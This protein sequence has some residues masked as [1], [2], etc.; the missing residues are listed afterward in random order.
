VLDLKRL[1]FEPVRLPICPFTYASKA[2]SMMK[3][4]RVTVAAM[5]VRKKA[6]TICGVKATP[7]ATSERPAETTV[8]TN[9]RVQEEPI[10]TVLKFAR[11]IRMV[12]YP[13]PVLV[14][15]FREESMFFS[16]QEAQI[17][18][19]ISP[20]SMSSPNPVTLPST[21]TMSIARKEGSEMETRTRR[22][23]AQKRGMG[24]ILNM[25]GERKTWE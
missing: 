25:V 11:E 5:A 4:K 2:M 15:T 14:Q 8:A 3:L 1:P 24:Y 23:N 17:P 20:I 16:S 18:N 21:R 6:T 9:P 10:V 7:N 19:R 12:V 22:M 13:A